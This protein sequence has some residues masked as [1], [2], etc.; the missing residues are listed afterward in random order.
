MNTFTDERLNAASDNLMK[1][2]DPE[3]VESLVREINFLGKATCSSDP[4]KMVKLSL[5]I[6]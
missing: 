5:I 1:G 6:R 4:E 3:E 2:V